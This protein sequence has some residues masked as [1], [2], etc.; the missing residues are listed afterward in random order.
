MR[1]TARWCVAVLVTLGSGGAARP[2]DGATIDPA[3]RAKARTEGRAAYEKYKALSLRLEEVSEFRTD[4][5]P[6]PAGTIP[7]RPQT[8]R[9]RVVRLADN[10]IL[11]RVRI[12]DGAAKR[13]QI[14]LECDNSDYNFT[15]GKSQEDSPYAL[16]DYSPGKR[17]F[18]LVNQVAGLHSLML[19][20]LRDALAAVENDA[21]HTLRALRF[22]D[23]RGLLR[24]EFTSAAGNTPVRKLLHVDPSHDWRV[25]EDQVETRYVVG[26]TRWSYGIAVGGLEFPTG[27]K[28]LNT[29]KVANAPPN[30]TVTGRLIS[31]KLTDRTPDDFRLSA[32][33]LQEPVDGAPRPRPRP[34][35]LWFLG[36]AGVCGVLSFTFAYLRRRRRR[37]PAQPVPGGNP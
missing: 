27:F 25:V 32:F 33:G 23:S 31:L 7:F 8:R 10:M 36:A 16:V 13:P 35:Y 24:I 17:K 2:G 20:S 18:P 1:A 34:W 26:S 29:Y 5:A 37:P 6:G 12:L 28:D 11:D 15:L 22:D 4:K 21:R 19:L 30:M 14:R 3:W 9:E